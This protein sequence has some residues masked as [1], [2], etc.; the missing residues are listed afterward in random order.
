MFQET[1]SG[2]N[3]RDAG[4][5][6]ERKEISGHYSIDP[7]SAVVNVPSSSFMANSF[8]AERKRRCWALSSFHVVSFHRGHSCKSFVEFRSQ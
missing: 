3:K 4:G 7:A 8:G 5:N 6:E 1:S 2:K